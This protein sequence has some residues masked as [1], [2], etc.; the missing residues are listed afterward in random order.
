MKNQLKH[1]IQGIIERT[2]SILVTL[3]RITRPRIVQY[4]KG[5][6]I[7]QN[8]WADS[9]FGEDCWVC[10]GNFYVAT[11]KTVAEAEERWGD[12]QRSK[13]IRTIKYL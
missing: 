2:L 1:T 10:S 12:I 5:Y 8:A 7:K 4:K 13:R 6:A 9:Y 3:Y 11:Y